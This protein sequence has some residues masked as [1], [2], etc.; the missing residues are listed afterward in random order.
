V[1]LAAS[2]LNRGA[3]LLLVV[4]YTRFLDPAGYGLVGAAMA[5]AEAIGVLLSLQLSEALS[6]LFFDHVDDAGRADV[7]ATAIIGILL[8]TGAA[9]GPLLLA[10]PTIAA[11]VAADRGAADAIVI[12]SLAVG[13][14]AMYSAG[15]HALRAELRSTAVLA[16]SSGRSALLLVLTGLFV[17]VL[18]FGALGALTALLT[19]NAIAA[20][21][22]GT[23]LVARRGRFRW[24]LFRTLVGYGA[25]LCPGWFAESAAK[26]VERAVIVQR[27]GLAAAGLWYLALRLADVLSTLVHGPFAQVFIV[28]RYQLHRD[29][30]PDGESAALFSVFLAVMAWGAVVLSALAPEAVTLVSGRNFAAAASLVPAAA[31]VVAVFSVTTMVEMRLYLAKRPARITVAV[32][33]SALAHGALAYFAVIH[34]G[35]VGVAWARLAATCLRI[36]CLEIAARGLPGPRP[37]WRRLLGITLVAGAAIALCMIMTD[38]EGWTSLAVRLGIALAFPLLIVSS[39]LASPDLRYRLF[40]KPL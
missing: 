27:I 18:G 30:S 37:E 2:L 26:A 7:V 10:A 23:A 20:I 32:V 14:D 13:C 4:I 12:A 21:A 28:R 11:F 15:L 31:A 38:V 9:A 29:G 22:L 39:P 35:V 40:R 6:R 5:A 16:W 24:P 36:V 3:G 25:P 17:S 1:Y 34:W 19:A 33:V 8:I